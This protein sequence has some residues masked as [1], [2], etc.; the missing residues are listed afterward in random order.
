MRCHKL[1]TGLAECHTQLKALNK[2]HEG[3]C[4][5][6]KELLVE[7]DGLKARASDLEGELETARGAGSDAE[8]AATAAAKELKQSNQSLEEQVAQLQASHAVN[9]LQLLER[10]SLFKFCFVLFRTSCN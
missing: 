4:S 9:L 2:S 8:K 7:Y 6:Y 3:I 5:D 10:V 1:E